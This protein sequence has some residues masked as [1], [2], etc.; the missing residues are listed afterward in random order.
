MQLVFTE[1]RCKEKEHILKVK[2]A[3]QDDFGN[4]Y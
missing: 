1:G 2:N 3:L 4:K